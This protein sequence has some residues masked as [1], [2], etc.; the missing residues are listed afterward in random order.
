MKTDLGRYN[1]TNS[2][3]YPQ[4]LLIVIAY[5]TIIG[6]YLLI[7][8]KGQGD[9]D[10]DNDNRGIWRK[11]PMFLPKII[12]CFNNMIRHSRHN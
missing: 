1:P 11:L 3:D 8:L 12:L 4:D 2:R 10:G 7:I 5:D 6:N 9:Y